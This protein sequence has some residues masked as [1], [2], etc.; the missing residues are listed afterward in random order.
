[1]TC[2]GWGSWPVYGCDVAVE[3]GYWKVATDLTLSPTSVD[4]I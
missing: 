3:Y 1:M 2:A 4:R